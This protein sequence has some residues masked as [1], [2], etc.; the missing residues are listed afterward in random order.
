MRHGDALALLVRDSRIEPRVGE[1]GEVVEDH[2]RD[3]DDEEAALE[4]RVVAV[5]HGFVERASDAG[6]GEDDLDED[7]AAHDAAERE[8]DHRHRGQHRVAHRV[9]ADDPAAGEPSSPAR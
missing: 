1:V 8:R 6:P 7:R 9:G 5:E 4:H 2:D 3:R